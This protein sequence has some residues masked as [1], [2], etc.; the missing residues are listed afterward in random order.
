[1]ASK[2]ENPAGGRGNPVV[3]LAGIDPES[4]PP[5][6]YLQAQRLTRRCSI[7]LTMALIVAPLIHGEARNA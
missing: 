4:K 5:L 1:M 2:M 3:D 6:A 7:S